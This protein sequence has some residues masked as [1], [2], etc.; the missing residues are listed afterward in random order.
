M[1]GSWAEREALTKAR[2]Q[3]FPCVS[4]L[5]VPVESADE[6]MSFFWVRNMGEGENHSQNDYE[7]LV[8]IRRKSITHC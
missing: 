4:T 8:E 7:S 3:L 5:L 1:K 6:L 2:Y